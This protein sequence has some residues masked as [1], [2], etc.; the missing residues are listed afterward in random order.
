MGFSNP[1]G[2]DL[3]INAILAISRLQASLSDTRFGEREEGRV[4]LVNIL[5]YVH[6]RWNQERGKRSELTEVN[7]GGYDAV[8]SLSREITAHFRKRERQ[9]F[10]PKVK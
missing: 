5:D 7:E 8:K 4:L 3:E 10:N 6:P 2:S 1:L 9:D